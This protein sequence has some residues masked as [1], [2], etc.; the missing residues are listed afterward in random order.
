MNGQT[1]AL[2]KEGL[3]LQQL[4]AF[5]FFTPF[6]SSFLKSEG[7]IMADKTVSYAKEFSKPDE[8]REFK[9]HG[10]LDVLSFENG[11]EG[12]SI[13]KG[14]FEPGW[15]WTNDLKPLAGTESC[16]AEHTGYCL[17]GKMVIKMNDGKEFTIKEGEAFYISPGH[18]AWVVGNEPCELLDFSGFREYAK[19]KDKK[20]AA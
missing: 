12:V 14:V 4:Q 2:L 20:E 13:G 5:C 10:H 18:D 1:A 19:A 15:K 11:R 3:K 17:K 6:A 16:E 7:S 8:R 9:G